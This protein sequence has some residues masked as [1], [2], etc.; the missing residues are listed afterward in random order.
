MSFE[1]NKIISVNNNITKIFNVVNNLNKKVSVRFDANSLPSLTDLKKEDITLV[2]VMD[3]KCIEKITSG[4]GLK[5]GNSFTATANEKG[6]VV[7]N[8]KQYDSN[9]NVNIPIAVINS[10][11]SG[12]KYEFMLVNMLSP[13]YYCI[14]CS[15]FSTPMSG[16]ISANVVYLTREI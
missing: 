3:T 4:Y 9:G 8:I 7:T 1:K 10:N 12:W 13:N 15:T 5:I 6:Q 11:R 14:E 16:E 2:K